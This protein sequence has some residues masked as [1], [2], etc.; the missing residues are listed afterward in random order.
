MS[1]QP[2]EK[3][4]G[5]DAFSVFRFP[6]KDSIS[7]KS[8]GQSAEQSSEIPS[9]LSSKKS[10]SWA[11]LAAGKKRQETHSAASGPYVRTS[12]SSAPEKPVAEEASG[13]LRNRDDFSVKPSKPV[14]GTEAVEKVEV[15]ES[16]SQEDAVDSAAIQKILDEMFQKGLEQGRQEG[17]AEQLESVKE[18]TRQSGFSEGQQQGAEQGFQQGLEKAEQALRSRYAVLE[19]LSDELVRQ[20]NILDDRQ[21]GL[22]ARLLEKLLLDILRVELRHSSER[23][24]SVVRESLALLDADDQEVLRVYLHPDDLIWVADLADSEHLT[25]RLIEDPQ[26]M[27]GGCRVEGALGDVDATLESRLSAGIEHIRAMLGNDELENK[28]DV[29]TVVNEFSVSVQQSRS[30]AAVEAPVIGRS[31]PLVDGGQP[32]TAAPSFSF[33]PDSSSELGAW[34]SLG[35]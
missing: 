23:I 3:N 18:E 16:Q 33:D 7:R 34:D 31:A 14:V 20:K 9:G 32:S 29:T 21:C 8:A 24:E 10:A 25:L 26:L 30:N 28:P 11:S 12:F 13:V 17:R 6:E 27:R 22:A 35:Q 5:V 2:E 1:E 19:H 15:P 4:Q